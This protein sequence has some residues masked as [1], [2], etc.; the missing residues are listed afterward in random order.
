MKHN[1][2]AT[3]KSNTLDKTLI[4][5]Q[6]EL[7]FDCVSLSEWIQ[8]KRPTKDNNHEITSLYVGAIEI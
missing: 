7:S 1:Q 4:L 3:H 2:I 6:C 5:M 8:I